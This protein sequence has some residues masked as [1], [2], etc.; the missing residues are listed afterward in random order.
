MQE[1]S[2]HVCPSTEGK[3]LLNKSKISKKNLDMSVQVQKVRTY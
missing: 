2:R 3:D 1:E